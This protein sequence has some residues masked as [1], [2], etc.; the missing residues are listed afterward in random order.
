M[1]TFLSLL[2]VLLLASLCLLAD[3][4][5]VGKWDC[6]A[7]SSNG[8]QIPAT[9]TVREDSGKL[10]G[11][12]VTGDGAELALVEPKLEADRFT[13]KVMVNGE[14][15]SVDLKVDGAKLSGKYSGPE[16]SGDFQAT[17]KP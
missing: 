5:I 10:S 9:M 11:T 3:S 13:F 6:N 2:A 7:T 15:Y 4:P 17:K 14:A 16:A 12:L 8:N 1:K